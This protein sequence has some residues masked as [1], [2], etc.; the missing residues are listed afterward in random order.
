MTKVKLC[1]TINN[2]L[3]NSQYCEAKNYAVPSCLLTNFIRGHSNNPLAGF[4]LGA[5]D[6]GDHLVDLKSGD[7]VI[8]GCVTYGPLSRL[9][10]PIYT[11]LTSSASIAAAAVVLPLAR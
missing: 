2:Y 5:F 10:E 9:D 4:F 7:L 1:I 11:F 3:R 8:G 6:V